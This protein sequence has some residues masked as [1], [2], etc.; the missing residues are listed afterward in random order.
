[1]NT[2]KFS[3]TLPSRYQPW[4]LVFMGD[5]HEGNNASDDVQFQRDIE[6][7]RRDPY[8]RVILL[9]DLVEMIAYRDKRF[10]PQ[11]HVKGEVREFAT[12]MCDGVI[13]KLKLI[14][15]KILFGLSGNHED[16]F[17]GTYYFD[18]ASY[19]YGNLSVPYLGYSALALIQVKAPYTSSGSGIEDFDKTYYSVRVDA[20]HGY[21]SGR[22]KGAKI[23]TLMQRAVFTEADVHVMGHVH[24][25]QTIV[26]PRLGVDNGGKLVQKPVAFVVGG[27]YLK[28]Y[29]PG[30]TGYG[31]VRGY[32]PVVIGSPFISI[33]LNPATRQ[34]EIKGIQYGQNWEKEK[35]K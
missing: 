7:V 13:A 35:T 4:N 26:E 29:E 33:R 31:E 24:D 6:T 2:D 15:D 18:A 8:S 10:R 30:V 23:N 22:T 21:G 14:A 17:L 12:S 32:R 27:T 3:I 19:I 34:M 11:V 28:T 5:I 25:I 16:D 1:M 9:G 20:H